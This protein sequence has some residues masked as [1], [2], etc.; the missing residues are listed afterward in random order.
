MSISNLFVPNNDQ[1]FCGGLTFGTS[2]TP[3]TSYVGIGYTTNVGGAV[4][5]TPTV[6]LFRLISG[7]CTL[8]VTGIPVTTYSGSASPIILFSHAPV[9]PYTTTIFPISVIAADMSR[10]TGALMIA[11]DGEIKIF[12]DMGTTEA[13]YFTT[14]CGFDTF[15][16]TYCGLS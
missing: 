9:L 3:M 6:G 7:T 11:V 16:V 10:S 2:G 12:K 5:S 1:L 13:S 14:N 15:S 4:V 8:S